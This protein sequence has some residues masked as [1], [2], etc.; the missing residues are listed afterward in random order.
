MADAE[1]QLKK[2]YA[3]LKAK[4]EAKQQQ[5][6]QQ[7][8]HAARGDGMASGGTEGGGHAAGALS[9]IL[10]QMDNSK[11]QSD[12]AR[13]DD[14]EPGAVV[15][16]SA[17]DRSAIEAFKALRGPTGGEPSAKRAKGQ[18]GSAHAC[19]C[20]TNVCAPCPRAA[21]VRSQYFRV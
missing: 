3:Q 21:S 7:Q 18:T 15:K 5:Q 1:E 19:L 9:G 14:K 2:K 17:L 16:A 11:P 12:E 6:Q 10:Q 4:R 20:G 13:G 8:Q